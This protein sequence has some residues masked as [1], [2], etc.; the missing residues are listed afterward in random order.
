MVATGRCDLV[1]Q[2]FLFALSRHPR[3]DE[4]TTIN[5]MIGPTLEVSDLEDL[6]WAVI[7]LPDFQYIR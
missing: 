4:L 1:D 6:L 3:P 5:A 7:M 2:L